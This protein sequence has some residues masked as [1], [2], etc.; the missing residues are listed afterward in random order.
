MKIILI[1]AR[2][3]SSSVIPTGL[4]SIAT[5]LKKEGHEI[6]VYDRLIYDESHFTDMKEFDA[7]LIG[8]SFMTTE[9]KKAEEIASQCRINFPDTTLCAGGYHVSALPERSLRDL[10]LD[11]V[12]IGEGEL[13]MKELCSQNKTP[14]EYAGIEGVAYIKEGGYIQNPA[15]GYADSLDGLPIIDRQLLDG[16]MDWYMTLPGNIRGQL[17]EKCTTIITSRGCPGNCVFCSSRAM[18]SEHVRQ[19]SVEN[20]LEEIDSLKKDY[21][22]K[23]LFF[24][25]D[26]FTANKK[27]VLKF[28]DEYKKRKYG[29]KW[30]CSARINTI[31][32]E[33][34]NSLKEAGCLQL[35]FG[36]ESGSDDILR[37]MQ[38]GQNR[39]TVEKAFDLIHKH[40]MKSLSCFIIGSPGETIAEM[41][42][43][44]ELAKKIESDFN[45]F[46]ILTPL[47][48]SKLYDMA[49][50]N[51]WIEKNPDFGMDWSIRHSENPVMGIEFSSAELLKIRKKFEDHFFIKNY[52]HYLLPLLMKPVFAIQLFFM[53]IK[54]PK[55]YSRFIFGNNSRRFS[56]FIESMYYDY[57][58]WKSRARK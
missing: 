55:K 32:D 4:L 54:S 46:S 10:N 15:R 48:G 42:L 23:G 29:I 33:V 19:R 45:I 20:V 53:I 49:V 34:L 5:L 58:E 6:K 40:K 8:I 51:G 36:I 12:V 2:C 26:T 27:W 1:N 11:F 25:D 47:P 13:T 39:K 3:S 41:N 28:C 22:I 18:W 24:L 16:G 52:L 17:I 21:G 57:K 56:G 7:D 37:F 50:K 38:K 9:Y 43:T 31:D 14:L 35:D 44:F 30:G